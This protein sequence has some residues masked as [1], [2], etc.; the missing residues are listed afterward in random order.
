M[1]WVLLNALMGPTLGVAAY[2]WA[3]ATTH[4]G[5]VLSIVA[6]SPVA[7]IPMAYWI[8]GDRP[9]CRSLLGGLLAV[10]GAMIMAYIRH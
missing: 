4:T 10:I 5:V 3:L 6:L 7:T 2:Q 1:P 9:P 8:S